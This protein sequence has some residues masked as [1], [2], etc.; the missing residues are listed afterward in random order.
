MNTNLLE[1]EKLSFLSF[2]GMDGAPGFAGID[3][4]PGLMGRPG[5]AGPPGIAGCNGSRVGISDKKSS[6][7]VI[8]WPTFLPQWLMTA[9]LGQV[10][11]VLWIKRLVCY[12][13]GLWSLHAV[14]VNLDCGF[15]TF[16]GRFSSYTI[17]SGLRPIKFGPD[18]LVLPC[19][20]VCAWHLFK[21]LGIPQRHLEH[22]I[23]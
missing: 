20:G 7:L 4:F 19:E 10:Y 21:Y 6:C 12:F 1:N 13:I 8:M 23:E 17:K 18:I 2:Q 9:F 3:G 16:L 15:H 5:P 22:S 11:N 14:N